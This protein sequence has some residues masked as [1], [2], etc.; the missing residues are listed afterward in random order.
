[1]VPFGGRNRTDTSEVMVSVL[2]ISRDIVAPLRGTPEPIGNRN[3]T[4]AKTSAHDQLIHTI[5]LLCIRMHG[6]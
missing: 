4:I 2:P 1:M 5:G 3:G 6:P